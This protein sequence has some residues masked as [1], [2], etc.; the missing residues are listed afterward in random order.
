MLA[1][2]P[3]EASLL[4]LVT[5]IRSAGNDRRGFDRLVRTRRNLRYRFAGG[6]HRLC[7]LLAE[8][9]GHAVVVGAPV[10]SVRQD[11]GGVSVTCGATTHR[12]RKLIVTAS[13]ALLPRIEWHPRLPEAWADLARRAQLGN[14]A[15]V[16]AVYERPFWRDDGLSGEVVSDDGP[17]EF[18][19]DSSPPSGTP[20]VLVGFVLAGHARRW[21]ELGPSERRAAAID[22]LVRYFGPRAASPEGYHEKAWSDDQWSTGCYGTVLPRGVLTS[23]GPNLKRTWEHV[24]FAG[25][26]LAPLWSGHME[27][28][29]RSGEQ[30]SE[31]VARAMA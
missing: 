1:A 9:L 22:C 2:E 12:A 11:A 5:H 20:G 8:Q 28:A 7:Q 23:L 14:V 15:K 24:H 31:A 3:R 10:T 30:A 27:G 13:P 4:G 25:A 29:V 16:H 26:D 6:S 17:V 18:V 19:Y 21:K